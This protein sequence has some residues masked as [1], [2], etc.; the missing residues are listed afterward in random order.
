MELFHSS[1]TVNIHSI[2]HKFIQRGC[3]SL[4][5]DVFWL[6]AMLASNGSL[7]CGYGIEISPW[8]ALSKFQ[9]SIQKQEFPKPFKSFHSV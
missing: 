5:L 2:E 7:A 8:Y 6:C 3:T 1:G 4:K 9:Y